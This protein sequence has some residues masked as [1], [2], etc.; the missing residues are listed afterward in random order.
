[1]VFLVTILSILKRRMTMEEWDDKFFESSVKKEDAAA[2]AER[3][4]CKKGVPEILQTSQE[5]SCA[6]FSFLIKLQV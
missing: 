3:L 4:F 1:M 2:V 6:K 5:D